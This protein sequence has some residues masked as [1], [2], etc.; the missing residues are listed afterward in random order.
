M[1]GF[2]HKVF[3]QENK[4]YWFSSY[5]SEFKMN[6]KDFENLTFN[7]YDRENILLNYLVYS[8]SNFFVEK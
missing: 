3:G 1:I 4:I 5:E 2:I 8:D 6:I 7:T